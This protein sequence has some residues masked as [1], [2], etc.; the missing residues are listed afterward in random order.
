[1]ITGTHRAQGHEWTVAAL[2][3][4]EDRA[5]RGTGT[6]DTFVPGPEQWRQVAV[7]GDVVVFQRVVG[8]DE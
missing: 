3:S 7:T 6:G 1:M 8:G 2:N 4:P 5:L